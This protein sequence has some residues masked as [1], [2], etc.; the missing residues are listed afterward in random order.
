MSGHSKWAN[1]KRRKEAVDGQRMKLFSKIGKEITVIVKQCGSADPNVNTKLKDAI[2][3]AKANNM[4]NDNIQ[5]CISR[6]A[7]EGSSANYENIVYEGYGPNGIAIIVESTTDNRNR[8]AADIRCI[9][10]KSGG[11][12]GTTGCVSWMFDKKGIIIIEKTTGINEDDLMMLSIDN[13]ADDF[14]SEEEYYEIITSPESFSE[15]LEKLESNGYNFLE[16][17]IKYVANNTVKIDDE[18]QEKLDKML[19]KF[20]DCDDVQNVWHNVEEE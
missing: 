9:F 17:E 18:V 20:N 16:A 6:A 11:N 4:P 15:V 1:I 7:G 14:V 13:G 3:K 10:D 2:A 8:S 12:M 5:R 19:D